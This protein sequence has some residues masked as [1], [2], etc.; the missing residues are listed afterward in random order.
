[1]PSYY[2][3][4]YVQGSYCQSHPEYGHTAGIQWACNALLAACWAKVRNITYWS[5]F[6]L[7]HVL[8]LGDDLYKHLGLSRYLDV[9]DL[10]H[11]VRTAEGYNFNVNKVHL[12]DGEAVIGRGKRFILNAFRNRSCAL[13]FII[14]TVTAIILHSRACY[15]FIH[16]VE[17]AEVYL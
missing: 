2:I 4:K 16:I 7:E 8:D 9:T 6:D 11:H 5:S 15:L 12:H 14:S 1:M 17:I 13:L 10:P 3:D